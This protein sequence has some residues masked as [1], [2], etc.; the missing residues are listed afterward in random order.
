M[1]VLKEVLPTAYIKKAVGI[2]TSSSFN[3]GRGNLLFHNPNTDSEKLV[4]RT[5]D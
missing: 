4:Y 1:I 3:L 2:T 5:D